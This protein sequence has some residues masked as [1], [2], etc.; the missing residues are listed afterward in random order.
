M[1]NL[2]LMCVGV[3]WAV[4]GARRVI[5]QLRQGNPNSVENPPS[6]FKWSRL[7]RFVDGIFWFGLGVATLM[8]AFTI[9]M[10]AFFLPGIGLFW[11]I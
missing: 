4:I 6:P 2:I 5:S 9:D 7:F 8:G 1:Q 11:L 10:A 3:F